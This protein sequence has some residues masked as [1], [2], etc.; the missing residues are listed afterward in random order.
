MESHR[1]DAA[2][3]PRKGTGIMEKDIKIGDHVV[4]VDEKRERRTS[5]VHLSQQPAG[6]NGW[7]L[8]EEV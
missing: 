7:R 6:A 2:P 4:Y 3:K 1:T 8:I 5:I